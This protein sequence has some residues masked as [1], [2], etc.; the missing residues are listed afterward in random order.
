MI[1]Y[2]V[3]P[4]FSRD[5]E[6]SIEELCAR[7][8]E[9]GLDEICFTTHYE[10]DPVR[11]EI[12]RVCVG[13]RAQAVGSDWPDAYFAAIGAARAK[14]P[15]VTVLVGVE[16]GYEPGLEGIIS[17]FL[18]RYPFDFV[19]GA[20]HCLDHVS[21]TAGDELDTCAPQPGV[22]SLIAWLIWTST[23]STS[24]PSLTGDSVR[25]LSLCCRRYS[26][27]WPSPAPAS[28]SIRRPCAGA[29]PNPTRQSVS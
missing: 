1:D 29:I 28:R 8:V 14:F 7:A 5:A 12:E 24:S 11:G 21:I 27:S 15:G 16:V 17:D 20:I 19:L 10:P 18:R 13:G 26:S 2:H 23:A 9:I 6:G 3:H 25:R 22:S 4:D